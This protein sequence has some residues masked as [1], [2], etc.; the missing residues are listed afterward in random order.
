MPNNHR[1]VLVTGASSGIGKCC[2]KYLSR[3]GCRVYG[4]IRRLDLTDSERRP[5][6]PNLFQIIQMDVTD[7]SSVKKG[8][9]RIIAIST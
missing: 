7:E 3:Q 1:V 4:T 9:D 6:N 2:A 8:I 5:S